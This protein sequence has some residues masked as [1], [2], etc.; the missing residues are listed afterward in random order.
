MCGGG[1]HNRLL[2]DRLAA[3]LPEVEVTTTDA[4]GV[5]GDWLEGLA[6]AWLAQQRLGGRAGNVPAVTG[7]RGERVL[8]GVWAGR[9][10]GP[11]D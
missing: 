7:A 6:F 8:G 4:R 5:D 9:P 11:G 3:A 1:R 2:M 10:G